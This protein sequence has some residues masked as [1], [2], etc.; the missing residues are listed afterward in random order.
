MESKT[1][2]FRKRMKQQIKTE[3]KAMTGFNLE[4]LIENSERGAEK[5]PEVQRTQLLNIFH[6]KDTTL[7]S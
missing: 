3:V 5:L 1:G 4:K 2:H 6:L 7:K